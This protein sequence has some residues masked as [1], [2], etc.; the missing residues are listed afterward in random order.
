MREPLRSYFTGDALMNLYSYWMLEPQQWTA[1]AKSLFLDRYR[2]AAALVYLPVYRL[3]GFNPIAL[4]ITL[5]LIQAANMLLFFR[6]CLR[7]VSPPAAFLAAGAFAYH[8]SMAELRFSSGTAY[9]T[10][11]V[12]FTL[13]GASLFT[14]WLDGRR[15]WLL[16]PLFVLNTWAGICA[17]E[18]FAAFPAILVAI[19]LFERRMPRGAS[20]AALAFATAAI[21]AAAGWRWS[22]DDALLRMSTY[23]P[24]WDPKLFSG[25]FEQYVILTYVVSDRIARVMAAL[26][27][28]SALWCLSRREWRIFAGIL[29]WTAASIAPLLVIDM[30]GGFVL[31][32][33]WAGIALWLALGL[34][35]FRR[36]PR[37]AAALAVFLLWKWH[38]INAR[39][40]PQFTAAYLRDHNVN[41]NF[42]EATRNL[43]IH[44]P[45]NPLLLVTQCWLVDQW[46]PWFIA[47]LANRSMDI[48]IDR[49]RDRSKPPRPLSD[50][51]AVLVFDGRTVSRD[52]LDSPACP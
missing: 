28:V 10:L 3:F 20:L 24:R 51:T 29:L 16:W 15:T 33:A 35:F 9:D 43:P 14:L 34:E 13:A 46:D 2:P 42:A 23:R 41:R 39:R 44:S 40:E 1:S 45:D 4:N 49:T 17:K 30:R 37:I 8:A 18:H 38:G 36:Y 7:W 31:Y 5:A 47:R 52:R 11:V 32:L 22:H 50:Y 27:A 26:C 6:L 48:H 19:L 25:N 12:F 21:L